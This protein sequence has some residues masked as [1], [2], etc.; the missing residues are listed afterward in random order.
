MP[1][2]RSSSLGVRSSCTH[3]AEMVKSH[4]ALL[5]TAV[6]SPGQ[7]LPPE[8]PLLLRLAPRA[9]W[10]ER[11]CSR[12]CFQIFAVRPLFNF[13]SAGHA[14]RARRRSARIR[15]RE[16]ATG[17]DADR[18][19]SASSRLD[20][21]GPGQRQRH[22]R[23]EWPSGQS[24]SH[25]TL[26]SALHARQ[27][28]GN[29]RAKCS[30]AAALSGRAWPETPRPNPHTAGLETSHPV[31]GASIFHL[32]SP[33][34]S[35]LT[36]RASLAFPNFR[37]TSS[38]GPAAEAQPG[39]LHSHADSKLTSLAPAAV[40][41]VED[42]TLDVADT[43]TAEQQPPAELRSELPDPRPR[44]PTTHDRLQNCLTA[45]A[46]RHDDFVGPDEHRCACI[47]SAQALK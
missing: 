2:I 6:V 33:V 41:E 29:L 44:T 9:F 42:E 24:S 1:L 32:Q 16:L 47:C 20:A 14:Q 26:L 27:H 17:T 7:A 22:W 13:A 36:Q 43:P 23:P 19:W 25:A 4:E 40:P 21:R 3:L 46:V 15:S 18:R 35:I 8:G 34:R 5:A 11:S 30:T 37:G 10:P 31:Q 39:S 45:M 28:G 38:A 12:H